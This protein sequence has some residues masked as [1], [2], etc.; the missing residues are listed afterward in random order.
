[1][2]YLFLSW[3]NDVRLFSWSFHIFGDLRHASCAAAS[4]PSRQDRAIDQP[5]SAGN[6]NSC[7][8]KFSDC[9]AGVQNVCQIL[10]TVSPGCPTL[11]PYRRCTKCRSTVHK[12]SSSCFSHPI[13]QVRDSFEKSRLILP[14]ILPYPKKCQSKSNQHRLPQEKRKTSQRTRHG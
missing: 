6:E 5:C 9:I 14:S 4:L 7:H 8:T 3:H 10:T 13:F 1:M 2:N 12:C 11:S